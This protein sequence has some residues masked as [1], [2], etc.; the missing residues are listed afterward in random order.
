MAIT[1]P[2]LQLQAGGLYS[3]G[4][5]NPA[6]TKT[7]TCGDS[8][9]NDFQLSEATTP[10]I[11][12][13]SIGEGTLAASAS[14]SLNLFDGSLLDADSLPVVFVGINSVEIFIQSTDLTSL[15]IGAGG[16]N[17]NVM[18]FDSKTSTQTIETG[19]LNFVQTGITPI[20]VDATNKL[21]K[22][23]NT[24]LESADYKYR[25]SGVIT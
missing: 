12:N 20:V 2:I 21:I 1:N 11:D 25:I 23:H 14:V 7:G 3:C 15:V 5:G 17:A 22:I 24:G 8:T 6:L 9:S 16:V 18:W 10:A 19:A 13:V 4:V